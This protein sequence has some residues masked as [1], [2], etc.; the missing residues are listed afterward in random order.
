M[1]KVVNLTKVTLG[2]EAG[3]T[4]GHMDLTPA[5][6]EFKFIFGIAPGGMCSFEYQ[7]VN[8]AVGEEIGIQVDKETLYPLFEHLQPPIMNLFEKHDTL[9]LKVKILKIEQ[10]ENTEIIKAMA[11]TA[12]HRHDCDCGCGC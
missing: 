5:A 11:E 6:S 7:L 12:S 8:K 10:P 1:N 3:T 2:L 9:H 4:A